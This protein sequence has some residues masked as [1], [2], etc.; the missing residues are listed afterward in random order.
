MEG[1]Q[2]GGVGAGSI[3]LVA[4][5]VKAVTDALEIPILL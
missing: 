3:A 2:H 5:D 1:C 4:K